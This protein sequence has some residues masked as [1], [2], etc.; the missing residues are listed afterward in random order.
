ML[1]LPTY[2][3][4]CDKHGTFDVDKP[5]EDCSREEL[6]PT[7]QSKASRVYSPGAM[8]TIQVNLMDKAEIQM[9]MAHKRDLESRAADIRS[10]VM[11]I[12]PKGPREFWPEI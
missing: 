8:H 10:G 4:L 6:C 9:H 1:P 3:Y 11:E 7:C 12:K 2:E 5:V